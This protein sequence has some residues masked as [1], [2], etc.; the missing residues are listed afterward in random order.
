MQATRFEF[1][2]GCVHCGIGRAPGQ[3]SIGNARM[4]RGSLI[5]W[6]D[7]TVRGGKSCDVRST[8]E[9]VGTITRHRVTFEGLSIPNRAKVTITSGS[10]AWKNGTGKLYDLKTLDSR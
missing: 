8:K 3:H 6:A 1:R 4:G 9:V 7:T 5:C 2:I 10:L